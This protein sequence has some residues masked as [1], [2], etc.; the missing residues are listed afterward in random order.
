MAVRENSPAS[1]KRRGA[2]APFVA[3][4]TPALLVVLGFAVDLAHMQNT[5][6]ELRLATD[7]A[8]RAG[9]SVLNRTD[10]VTAARAR[11]RDIAAANRVAG[12]PLT[13]EASDVQFGR[14]SLSQSGRQTFAVGV[15]PYNAVR[16]NGRRTNGSPAGPVPLYF[17]SLVGR[18]VFE[19]EMTAV[20]S[21]SNFD[22]CL[23]LDRS[24]S[25]K[26]DVNDPASGMS[27]GDPRLCQPPAASS[28]WAS[29]HRAVNVFVAVLRS[30][31]SSER[32]SVVTYS[33]DIAGQPW[34]N[35]CGQTHRTTQAATVDQQLAGDLAQIE[36]EMNAW[37]TSIFN[38]NTY[39]EQGIKTG[40][41]ELISSRA[42]VG[43]E[44]VLIVLTDGHENVGSAV[45]GAI[46]CANN[47][48]QCHTITFSDDAD[49]TLMS[50]VADTGG[51]RH[52]HAATEQE[53]IDAFR[54]MAGELARVVE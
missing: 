15:T 16:V 7:A 3:V 27:V 9:A 43:A 52:M 40:A 8:A 4:L 12:S 41:K 47:Q 6:A 36:S 46:D 54:T 45:N 23:V 48:I 10:S 26:L 42:R 30:S 34:L 31:P 1:R 37:S 39:I 18:S 44:K 25:M 53:L 49:Q 38:G 5:R 50:Q 2:V 28:R 51:G 13:L 21:F 35:N 24:S 29:L 11:A 17:G 20:A 19:P 33:S 14:T 22:I 32:V